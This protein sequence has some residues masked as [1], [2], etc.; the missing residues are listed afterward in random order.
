MF[1]LAARQHDELSLF[2]MEGSC[3]CGPSVF[4][5]MI[6]INGGRY[7]MHANNLRKFNVRVEEVECKSV[8][9]DVVNITDCASINS[10]NI[11]Y[12]NDVDF[13]NIVVVE[14]GDFQAEEML[15][16]Q[17]ISPDKISHLSL[18]QQHELLTV[19]DRYA[20]VF[21]EQGLCMAVQ[22]EVNLLPGFTPKRL[23]AYRI[24]QNYKAEVDR[25][26]SEL[27]LFQITCLTLWS[28]K[29]FR[30]LLYDS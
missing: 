15:P 8:S 20:A 29:T 13:G 9:C 5:Y 12:E 21:S 14:T 7:H 17:K 18:I 10:C 19:L 30:M 16:S 1:D 3:Y 27:L 26:V 2:Q 23:R 6:E 11:I 25:Q 4:P 28:W 22:H 24:P